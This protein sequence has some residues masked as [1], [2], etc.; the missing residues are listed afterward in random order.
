VL[1]ENILAVPLERIRELKVD[2][3]YVGGHLVYERQLSG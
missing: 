1:S 3:T 2:Q